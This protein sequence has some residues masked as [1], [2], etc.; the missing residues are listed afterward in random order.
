MPLPLLA[1]TLGDPAGI[2][3]EVVVGAWGSGA[4]VDVCRACV[5]GHPEVARRAVR[6]L[7]LRLEIV[8]IR[9]PEEA[10]ST[11]ESLP[12]LRCTADEATDVLPASVDARGGRA[13]HDAVV[14]GAQLALSRRIDA[15]VTAPLNK[16]AL[17]AAGFSYPGHTEL[18]AALCGVDDAGMMLY[19]AQ[20][21]P[22]RGRVGLGVVHA[23]LHVA[24]SGVFSQLT[25]GRV[26]NRARQL[27]HVIRQLLCANGIHATP[28]IAVS[29]LNPH[30]GE[31]GLFGDEEERIIRPAVQ[32]AMAAGLAIEGPLSADTLFA[33][34]ASGAYD[35]VVAMYHDQG[36]I[37]LKLLDMY[38]AVN[39]TLGLPIIRTS[40]AHGTAF[41]LAW[42]GQAEIQGMIEAVRV[43]AHLARPSAPAAAPFP[44]RNPKSKI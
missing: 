29:S 9:A 28:R 14:L 6:L 5:L 40:V 27:D 25:R 39:V 13:A 30:A 8:E 1:M 42:R 15:L 3:A 44:D 37:A 41:D 16:A 20:G 7:G 35:G 36:H 11:C 10:V 31:S 19:L 18:L 23:T 43:A 17:H 32:D 24:L 21:G 33:R 22:V 26:V 4:L 38:R 2:G 34:A 12:C